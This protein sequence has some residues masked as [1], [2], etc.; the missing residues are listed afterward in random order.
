MG[1]DLQNL[2]ANGWC[3]RIAVR[4]KEF[5][6]KSKFLF[7]FLICKMTIAM[8]DKLVIASDLPKKIRKK[9]FK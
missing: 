7:C 6:K 2:T 3:V 8:A 1:E 5:K 4:L 9:R